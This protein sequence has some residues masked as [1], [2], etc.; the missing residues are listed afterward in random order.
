MKLAKT[1][2]EKSWTLTTLEHP[3]LPAPEAS[4]EAPTGGNKINLQHVYT[5]LGLVFIIAF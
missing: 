2:D 1:V 5:I 3:W 4:M